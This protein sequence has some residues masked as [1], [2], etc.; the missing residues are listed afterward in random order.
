MKNVFLIGDSIR[1]N[2]QDEVM[3]LLDGTA[4][5]YYPGYTAE[6]EAGESTRTNENARW[7]G[8]TLNNLVPHLWLKHLPEIDLVHWNNGIWDA[9]IRH[10]EDGSFTPIDQYEENVRRILR[11]LRKQTPHIIIATTTPP[12]VDNRRDPTTGKVTLT[13][14]TVRRYN[15]VLYKIA[16]EQDLPVNDLFELV[17]K[18]REQYISEDEIHLNDAGKAACGKQTADMIRKYLG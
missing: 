9:V 11:E 13:V 16:K 18:D 14:E 8:Y 17:Y 1:M 3:R 4:K 12:K 5:I 10:E 7:T 2:Y 15:A 6:S